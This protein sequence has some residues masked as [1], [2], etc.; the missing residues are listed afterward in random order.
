M[1]SFK[2]VDHVL[3]NVPIGQ[4]DS[5][6]DFYSN[7][8]KLP[9]ILGDRPFVALW[10]KIGDI[11]LH[12][13][14]EEPGKISSRHVALEVNDLQSAEKFLKQSGIE[15]SYSSKLEGRERLFFRDPFNNRFE[16]LQY[17]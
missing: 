10:F 4:L 7:V 6:C 13:T 5:A 14:E 9:I 16:L 15:V 3:I 11:E 2:K 8:L 12:I 1:I 17:I